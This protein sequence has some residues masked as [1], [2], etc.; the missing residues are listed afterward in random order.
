MGGDLGP[1]AAVEGAVQAARELAIPV[2][3]VGDEPQIR[4]CLEKTEGPKAPVDVCHA[5]TVVEMTDAPGKVLRQKRDSSMAVA[6]GLM[7]RG[8]ASALVSPGNTG[9]VMAFGLNILKR[10]PGVER[11]AIAAV[12][13]T[14]K[15]EAVMLD[16]GANV[17]CKPS[18]LAQFAL[19][20]EAY[21]RMV[22]GKTR[23]KVALLSNGSEVGK[24]NQLTRDAA[25]LLRG[26]DIDFAGPIEGRD[27]FRGAVDVVVQDGFVG[28]VVLKTFEGAVDAIRTF[29]RMEIER[30]VVSKAAAV[31]LKPAFDRFKKRLDY[32]EYGGAPLLGLKGVCIVCHGASPPKAFKNA[33]RVASRF[34]STGLNDALTTQIRKNAHVVAEGRRTLAAER[35]ANGKPEA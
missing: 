31:A 24:G 2:V 1:A 15:G 16:M 27:L 5:P 35:R 14:V 6:M 10:L 12:V 3:I 9:A 21:A 33:I 7:K 13:P 4:A 29:L 11:P 19:M 20:G 17:D 25:R 26:I 23:P 8:E 22:Q 30:S 32:S 28:N 18:Y 34:A